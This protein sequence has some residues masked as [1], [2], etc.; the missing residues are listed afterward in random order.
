MES[1]GGRPRL[2]IGALA[3]VG[4]LVG[5]IVLVGALSARAVTSD[6]ELT[7]FGT[8]GAGPGAL[9][10]PFGIASD[11][12]TG[13]VAVVPLAAVIKG[14]SVA[15]NNRV[16]E[17]TAWGTFVKG[18]GWDVA[19]GAVN[20]QQE[21]RIRA[22]SGE[23]TLSFG[24]F[25]TTDLAFDAP[26]PELEGPQSVEAALNALPSISGAAGTVAVS[27]IPGTPDGS[28]PYVYVM[29][30]RGGLAGTDVGQI[31]ASNGSVPLSGGVPSTILEARTRANGTSGGTGLESC[32]FESGC[33]KGSEG[34]GAG[35]FADTSTI[36]AD[37]SGNL[38]VYEQ[39]EGAR[40]QKFS[41]DGR[42][43]L[44]FGGEVDK[45]T[46]ANVCTAASGNECGAG[47][48]GTGN[49][50]FTGGANGIA[51]APNGSVFVGDS[52]RIQ[53]F[54]A[55]GVF[56]GSIA[57]PGQTVR[58]L[59]IDP[60]SGDLYVTVAATGSGELQENVRKLDS[61]TGAQIGTLP[62][63]RPEAIAVDPSGTVYVVDKAFSSEGGGQPH[64][65]SVLQFKSNGEPASPASCC[66]P[67]SNFR[68]FALG[69][70]A[71]G[72]LYVGNTNEGAVESF[73]SSYGPAPSAFEAPAKAPPKIIGQFA[74]SVTPGSATVGAF[75]NPEF[76]SDT[77]FFVE[78]GVGRCS[79]GGCTGVEP[80]PPGILLTAKSVAAPLRSP[81]IGL[82]GLTPSTT[83]HYRIVAQSS[84]GGPVFGI[85]PDGSGPAK[86][87]PS[88]GL[89]G[90]FTTFSPASAGPACPN[91]QY[92][93][94]ASVH[95]P[96]CR[97]YEMVSPID[98]NGA[99]IRTALNVNGNFGTA[100]S[101]SAEDGER[102]TYSAYRA[103]ADAKA[104]PFAV[105]YLATRI[106]GS[107]WSTEAIATPQGTAATQIQG[108]KART[109]NEF[110]AFSPDLCLSWLTVA[111]EPLPAPGALEGYPDLFRRSNCGTLS[112]A[113]LVHPEQPLPVPN[114]F[115]TE[116]QGISADGSAA[117]IR[118]NAKL[119][120]N[121]VGGGVSQTYYSSGGGN[122][123]LICVLPDGTPSP[124]NCAA[125][126]SPAL[127]GSVN[128]NITNH[129]GLV[130]NALSA[131]GSRVYWTAAQNSLGTGQIYLRVN[132][133]ADQG[134][135]GC[136]EG[137]A[138]TLKVSGLKSSSAARF[139]VA[140]PDG[141]KALFEFVEGALG[142]SLYEY[143]AESGAA[144]LIAKK[145]SGLA[146]AGKSLADVYFISEEKLPGTTG[147]TVGAPNLYLSQEGTET[148]IATLSAK[149][150]LRPPE[151]QPEGASI[152]S[153]TQ[154][155]PVYH[156]A[157]A[158]KDG[159]RLL[160]ISDRSLTGYDNTDVT[161]ELPCGLKEGARVGICDSEVYLYKVGSPGPVCISCNPGGAQ[162]RGRA[163]ER[164][165]TIG[166]R[167]ATA[168]S[169]AL[170]ENQLYMPGAFSAD[171]SKLFFNS[172]DALVPRD[173]NGSEDVYQWAEVPSEA[174]CVA[175]GAETYV[176][177]SGGCLSLISS[178][179]SAGD[180]ELLDLSSNGDDIFFSTSASLVPQDPGLVDVYDARVN[181]GL[182]VHAVAAQCQDEGCQAKSAPPSSSSPGS[183]KPG[184]G[185]LK[186]C[187]KVSH[188][189]SKKGHKSKK[190]HTAKKKAP[191]RCAKKKAK[192][193]RKG[194]HHKKGKHRGGG[195][196]STKGA[197]R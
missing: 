171:G 105:Q 2:R 54:S 81:G 197:K 99:D 15:A 46:K 17:F 19:P 125:G 95:L 165:A 61:L 42:F 74:T 128:S 77:R 103:F 16:D 59:A 181:G 63:K 68:F 192:H 130:S 14:S 30:F 140:S 62:V 25:T 10:F 33:Q 75:I 174:Q 82:N 45:T 106:A 173:T 92:R 121:A 56:E 8:S 110:K 146:G 89:E 26:G 35:Q 83:Y 27:A 127:E 31:T 49:G 47:V 111:A 57:I 3:L 184:P 175:N 7:R 138:C 39:S 161:S 107:E 133:T 134:T 22:G 12:N 113:A 108:L 178:G 131:D 132:P 53:R 182:P 51:V 152:P 66:G 139:L 34:T 28:T 193:H 116:L 93:N 122:L 112:Y 119:T 69:T 177:S 120:P 166:T 94:G 6:E 11:P 191:N 145:V 142:R 188:S 40:V 86:P 170:A 58:A 80:L 163:V 50:Q 123:A 84:G 29:A 1:A 21:L 60:Q 24:G 195:S 156:A 143:D 164:F 135:T 126:T 101:Q 186:P 36:A 23:F 73:V 183:T 76:W 168:A 65:E 149:D 129:S 88:E 162:P 154:V 153:N 160:F 72:D 43:L 141:G 90:T 137:K 124:G 79:E 64:P 144:T 136:E 150:V 190:A 97:A 4:A 114:E 13:H 151:D 55:G 185:N 117:L 44:M 155:L 20:E 109:D 78:Y 194:H 147:A 5:L 196:G 169:P 176:P 180:S 52:E 38:Y 102:F 41:P 48:L 32:T 37:T 179:E 70:N 67:P 100:V 187:K 157:R 85:D 96:D 9:R 159:S 172:Y 104:A 87:S 91:E 98:K 167:L 148:F 189:K 71:I 118:A 115:E 18:F 158:S